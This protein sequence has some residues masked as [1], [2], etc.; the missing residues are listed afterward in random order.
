VATLLDVLSVVQ[1]LAL[2]VGLS[3]VAYWVYRSPASVA[4]DHLM[5]LFG[6]A[7]AWAWFVTVRNLVGGAYD[8]LAWNLANLALASVAVYATWWFVRWVLR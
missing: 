8:N 1:G 3:C 6:A 5:R 4:R 2:A 7:S